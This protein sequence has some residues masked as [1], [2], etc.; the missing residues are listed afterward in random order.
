MIVIRHLSGS[1]VAVFG[2]ARSGLAAISALATGGARVYAWDD[3]ASG[4]D[5]AKG[6]QAT[7][8][9]PELMPWNRIAAVVLSPGVPLTHPA[10]HDIV[11]RAKAL[12]IPVIGDVELFAHRL[13]DLPQASLIGITGTNG[14]STTTALIGHL[15]RGLGVPTAVGGNIG[16]AVLEL[17]ALPAGGIYAIELSSYQLDLAPSLHPRVAIQLN[18]TPDHIDRHGDMAGYAAAKAKL[19]AHLEAGDTAIVGVD[20]EWSLA[21]HD[22]LVARG[23]APLAISIHHVVRHG[24]YVLDGLLFEAIEGNA[25]LIGDLKQARALPG[26]HNWQNAAAAYLALR[27][28]GHTAEAVFAQIL[29]FPG[30]AHRMELVAERAGVRFV[31]DSKATNADAA[32]RALAA[33]DRIH[34]IAGGKAKAGGIASLA[35]F[36]PRIAHAY[37]IGDAQDAFAATLGNAVPHSLSGDLATAVANAA[38]QAEPGSVVLLSPACASFDQ[39]RDFEQRGDAFRAAVARALERAA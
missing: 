38:A 3:N 28:L 11:L 23:I 19:F 4:R 35:P 33:Y 21:L 39:F 25:R 20:D 18:L 30:L 22:N 17:D 27:A 14:K 2:L 12:G 32:A 36:F 6:G 24:A 8:L 37:L 7:L 31:N 15:S 26:A 29:G 16:Q 34:W 1:A 10:P 13:Q 5:A 9:P